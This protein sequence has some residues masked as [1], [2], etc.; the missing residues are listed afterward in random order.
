MAASQAVR[1]G[2]FSSAAFRQANASRKEKRGRRPV[3][4]SGLPL[5]YF[6]IVNS[7]RGFAHGLPRCRCQPPACPGPNTLA[8]QHARGNA[9]P[10]RFSTALA[11]AS[12]NFWLRR[13]SPGR[14]RP[15][16]DRRVRPMGLRR[17]PPAFPAAAWP[18]SGET[19]TGPRLAPRYGRTWCLRPRHDVMRPQTAPP[20]TDRLHRGLLGRGGAAYPR[21][22][23]RGHQ[24]S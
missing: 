5:G 19:E 1:R 22:P 18:I 3:L 21:V 12:E 8:G 24:G 7:I 13:R 23:Q 11:R 10:R 2:M 6:T 16:G 4:R 20:G 15:V 17:G 14:G 9:K